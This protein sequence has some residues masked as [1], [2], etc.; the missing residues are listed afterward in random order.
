MMVMSVNL[1]QHERDDGR[2]AVPA[3]ERPL[4]P[5]DHELTKSGLNPTPA[6]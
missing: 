3:A 1:S 5:R 4:V 6:C 2:A